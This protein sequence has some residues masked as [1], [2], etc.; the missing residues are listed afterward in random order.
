MYRELAIIG[1]EVLE[2]VRRSIGAKYRGYK[3]NLLEQ[4]F[5][6]EQVES[7]SWETDERTSFIIQFNSHGNTM[8][9]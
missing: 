1:G 3:I 9:F 2:I 8:D 7:F 5:R 6:V 4:F